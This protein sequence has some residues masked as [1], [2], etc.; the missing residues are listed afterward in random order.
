MVNPKISNKTC[1]ES[2]SVSFA[3]FL[4]EDFSASSI[5]K[6]K[7]IF[8]DISNF[9]KSCKFTGKKD[10][11]FI[12][13]FKKDRK[14]IHLIFVGLGKFNREWHKE[15]ECLR[16]AMG[17][18]I[19]Q[20][21][22]LELKSCALDLPEAKSLRIDSA[23]LAKQLTIAAGMADYEFNQFKSDV[24]QKAFSIELTFCSCGKNQEAAA[25][26]EGRVIAEVANKA[27]L[28]CDT[29]ANIATPTVIAKQASDMAAKHSSLTCKILGYKEAEKLSMG[30]FLA[31]DSGSEQPG[32]FVVLEY[33][34]GNK[35]AKTVGLVGKGVTFDTG[36]VNLKPY[37]HMKNMKLDMCGAAAVIFLMEAAAKLKLKQNIVAVTPLVEN[38]PSGSALRQDDII[39][40]MNGKTAEISSTDAE[41]R[42]I[43]ADGLCYVEKFYKPDVLI[44][45]ATLTGGSIYA[46][47][48]FFTALCSSDKKLNSALTESGLK[49]GDRVWAIPFDDDFEP[50]IKSK[51][52]DLDNCGKSS[53]GAGTITAGWFLRSFVEKT[54][55]AHLDIAS[56]SGEVPGVSYLGSGA[57][58]AG[59]RLLIDFIKNF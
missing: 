8:P 49:T 35:G 46:L 29:P 22:K 13:P 59:L 42:L 20:V 32:K 57:T 28:I 23:E 37:P 19:K 33:K 21:K 17:T 12:L 31:V 50:A 3:F 56:T 36:G 38:M 58:A 54:P 34:S 2:K 25:V 4:K 39:T 44:D 43:L 1:L 48:H 27:R 5:S 6:I 7:E 26:E 53:Y 45:I 55:W 16:R 14:I 41:G 18:T 10:S 9:L 51:I 30:G 52:A 47:G 11:C 40:F 24:L 15:L